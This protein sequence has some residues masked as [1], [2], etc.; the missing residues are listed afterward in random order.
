MEDRRGELLL[1]EV[2]RR[3]IQE[4]LAVTGDAEYVVEN[5]TEVIPSKV[6]SHHSTRNSHFLNDN[7]DFVGASG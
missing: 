6:N 7:F 5:D 2:E 1:R 4:A 3:I